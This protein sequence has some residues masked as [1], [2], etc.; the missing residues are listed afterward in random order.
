[1][2]S[3]LTQEGSAIGPRRTR[4][5]PSVST[6]LPYAAT[7][8]CLNVTPGFTLCLLGNNLMCFDMWMVTRAWKLMARSGRRHYIVHWTLSLPGEGGL[9]LLRWRAKD[10]LAL[11][12]LDLRLYFCEFYVCWVCALRMMKCSLAFDCKLV[13][14]NTGSG[15][16]MADLKKCCCHFMVQVERVL[17][18]CYPKQVAVSI[19]STSLKRIKANIHQKKRGGATQ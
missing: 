5:F 18:T 6:Q 19:T 10:N 15:C 2:P 16:L 7:Y 4:V 11:S 9:P 12:Y 8:T 1:M 3:T 13:K 14:C 17:T